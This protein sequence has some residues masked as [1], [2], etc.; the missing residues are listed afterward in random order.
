[1]LA[2]FNLKPEAVL[3]TCVT[4]KETEEHKD[5][6]IASYNLEDWKGRFELYGMNVKVL[7]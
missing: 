7:R 1:M 5:H 2:P 4:C 6:L 3:S